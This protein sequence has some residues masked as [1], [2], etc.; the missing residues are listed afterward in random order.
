MSKY[1]NAFQGFVK[2]FTG[3]AKRGEKGNPTTIIGVAPSKNIKKF[4]DQKEKII[5]MTD[6]YKKKVNDPEVK[7]SMNEGTS[8]TLSNIS[9]IY[10]GEPITKKVKKVEKKAMGGRIGYKGGSDDGSNLNKSINSLKR[11]IE[12]RKLRKKSKITNSRR[13]RSPMERQRV[14]D[15]MKSEAQAMGGNIRTAGEMK[16]LKGESMKSFKERT[17]AKVGGRIGRRL[18]GGTNMAK[19]KTNIQKIRETFAP[20]NKNLKPVDKKKQKG[21]AKLPIE[22]RNKMGYAKKGG[23]A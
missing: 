14:L 6:S 21:L 13:E 5:K 7:K 9:K 15:T 19:R 17:D 1:H 20:K 23:R 11:I 12:D 2:V 3:A 10:K 4:T 16:P 8:K 18:G 22:V